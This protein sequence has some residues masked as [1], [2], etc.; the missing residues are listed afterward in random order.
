MSYI[1]LK[2]VS[3]AVV[4]LLSVSSCKKFIKE[5]LVTV[6]TENYYKTDIG[7][8]DLVRSAY[9]PLKWRF[10]GEQSYG[11]HNFGVDEFRAGDQFNNVHYNYYD[12]N[13]NSNEPFV[14]GLWTNNYAGIKRCNMGI[15]FISDFGDGASALLGTVQKRNVRI[16][17]LKALRAFYYFQMVQQF[18]GVPLVTTYSA[19]PQSE[20]PRASVAAVY[21]QIISDFREA[22]PVLDWRNSSERGRATRAM[23]YH[24]LA[25]A[26]LTRGSSVA[27]DRGKKPSDMDSVI[28]FADSVIRFGGHVL[29]S[30]F[31][32]LFNASYPDGQVPALGKDG[33]P[34]TSS[35]AKIVAN[36]NSNEIIFAANFSDNLN[37]AGLNNTTH[38]YYPVQYDAG[39][40]GTDGA[41]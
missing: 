14:N 5:E 13:L 2:T 15:K 31:G 8:E 41:G 39:A 33:T 38:L 26:Y 23:A 6:L 34:P 28:V 17:E 24:F 32:N 25:K 11:M 9:D 30:D 35:K 10:T 37:L 3:V 7:L 27:E 19:E 21:N 4:F 18:G 20:F 29:E 22:G 36:N 1:K 12:A 16:A 40:D